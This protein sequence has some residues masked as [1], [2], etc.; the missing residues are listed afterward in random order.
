M[1]MFTKIHEKELRTKPEKEKKTVA[2][3]IA[4]VRIKNSLM[5]CYGTQIALKMFP[6]AGTRTHIHIESTQ[7]LVG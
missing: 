1:G 4:F 2:K 7:T 5:S 6:L 3:K